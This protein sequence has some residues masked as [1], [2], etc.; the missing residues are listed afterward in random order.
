MITR[1]L[2]ALSALAVSAAAFALPSY[3]FTDVG[4]LGGTSVNAEA[5]NANGLVAGTASL[6]AGGVSPF[7][8]NNGS[9][10]AIGPGAFTGDS[11]AFGINDSGQIVGFGRF[12][13]SSKAFLYSNG[14]VQNLGT[15]NNA[16]GFSVAYDINNSGQIV[17]ETSGLT[18][19]RAF[20]YENGAMR[21]LGTLGGGTSIAWAIND[22]GTVTG[23]ASLA[24][25]QQHAFRYSGST[26]VGLGTLGG[27]FS[28]GTAISESGIIVGS[29]NTSSGDF[30]A[31]I[32]QNGAMQQLQGLGGVTESALG[33]NDSGYVVGSSRNASNIETAFFHSN[34]VTTDLNTLVVDLPSGWRLSRANAI[35]NSGYITGYAS[36]NGQARSFLL[37]PV[38]EPATIFAL[39]AGALALM[40]R[41]RGN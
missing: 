23:F 40:R 26:M 1:P 10:S 33:V 39:G 20:I 27:D 18:R 8:S 41:R 12:G 19:G 28:Q 17:G 15:F 3:S 16:F 5:V 36:F 14:T 7:S 13:G 37:R 21:G 25:G 2:F 6:P 32:Y 11:G 29:S 24:N 31:F 22:Q 30:R 35:S 34:G 9:T 4:T 38:P